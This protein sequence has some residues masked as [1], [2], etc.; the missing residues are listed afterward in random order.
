MASPVAALTPRRALLAGVAAAA[1]GIGAFGATDANAAFTLA[2]CQGSPSVRGQGASF[3][4]D[5]QAKFKQ[6]FEGADG[7]QGSVTGPSFAANGSGNGI[8][9]VGGGG[10]NETLLGTVA[11]QLPRGINPGVRDTLSAFSATDEPLS[12]EQRNNIN[13]GLTTTDAD[14]GKIHLIPI[15]TGASAFIIH[16]PAGCDLSDV[17]NKTNGATDAFG[18]QATGD[19]A[20]NFTSRL[21]LTNTLL[22]KAWAGDADAD[23]WGEIAPGIRGTLSN[24]TQYGVAG[25]TNCADAPVRRIV[26]QDVS[27]TTYGWKAF[28]NLIN[29]G[30]GWLTTYNTPDNRTWPTASGARTPTAI[31]SDPEICSF[32]T[33]LCSGRSSGGGNMASTVN[34]VEGSIGYVDLATARS[35]GF[36]L[37]PSATLAGQDLT[38]WSPLQSNPG[39]TTGGYAEPTKNA[40]AH[41]GSTGEKGAYC[42]NVAIQNAPTPAGSPENDPTLGDWSRAFAAGGNNGYPACVLTY[43]LAWDDNAAVYG[44]TPDEEAKARTIKDYLTIAASSVA[45]ASISSVDYSRLPNTQATPLQTWAMNA[46]AAIDW[47]KSSSGGGDNRQPDTRVPTPDT[48]VP[49]PD[50]RVPTPPSNSFSIPSSKTSPTLITFSVQLPGAGS[51]KVAATTKVGKKTIKVASATASPKGA[52]KITLRLKLSSAA[53]KALAR[54][55]SKKITVKVAFTYTPTGGTAKTVTKNVTV[56]AAKKPVKRKAAKR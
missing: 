31:T 38:Y 36:D 1:V 10:G 16:L 56:K 33:K 29:P 20:D 22:E 54:A 49:T 45:Q 32:T 14:N 27:G 50:N 40:T 4:R 46:V 7:C 28:L 37:T 5:L 51:L 19:R 25:V 55:K 13:A 23:T 26:R 3:Q 41:V 44:N 24:T 18:G 47:N 6:L 30:R 35:T 9:S 17:A 2:R 15:A 43:I 21:R 48:R 12:A 8:A 39:G 53:K 52:S 34:A 42:E 11:G